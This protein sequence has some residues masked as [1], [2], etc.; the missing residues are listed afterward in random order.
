[1]KEYYPRVADHLL[2]NALKSSGAVLIQGPKWCGKTSTAI[3]KSKSQLFLQNPDTR[4]NNL[5]IAGIKPSLLLKGETPRLIDEWQL[6]PILW[7]SVRH[8]VDMRGALGQFVLTGSSIPV[9]DEH[10]SH[11]GAGRISRI[12]MRTM[13]LYESKESTGDISLGKLFDSPYSVESI[14][15]LSIEQLAHIIVRG[16][17]PVSVILDN[18]MALKRVQDYVDAII[19]S[20]ISRVDGIEKNPQKVEQLLKSLARN[21]ATSASMDTIRQD[22][23]EGDAQSISFPTI[24]TYL[25]SLQRLFVVEDL[26]AWNPAIR[27][28]TPLRTAVKRHFTDPSIATALLDI[29]QEKLLNDFNTFGYLFESLCIRDLR[30]YADFL[31]GRVFHYRDKTELEC[32][33][34]VVLRDGRWAAIEIKM[35]AK[36]FDEAADNLFRL[37]ERIDT[38]KM[39]K[40]SCKMILSATDIGYTREDGIHVVP[41]GSLKW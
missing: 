10:L 15:R 17:W 11:T 30:V 26:H 18:D 28:K 32:D 22:T 5:R 40:P 38:S 33:A 20:D 2:E 6:A 34:I 31:G 8:E 36:E 25:S 13:S 3:R 21:T 37:Q 7:D 16:G 39:M 12:R 14:A 27:S 19:D 24:N 35:G 23:Q 29:D 1:M 4:E 41:I 9:F